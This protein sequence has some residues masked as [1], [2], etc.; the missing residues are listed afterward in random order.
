P[1]DGRCD[2]ELRGELQRV[3]RTQDLLEVPARAR[4]VGDD[5]LHLLVRADDEHRANGQGVVR[6]RVNHVVQRRD[7]PIGVSAQRGV[8][9]GAL[10]LRDGSGP[11]A[12]ILDGVHAQTEH[13]A[14]A[15]VEL[16]L[17]PR[18]LAELGGADRSESLRVREEHAP[19]V[20]EVLVEPNRAFRAI[21][22]EVGS[23]VAESNAHGAFLSWQ[24]TLVLPE[25]TSAVPRSLPTSRAKGAPPAAE[26][27][28]E[29]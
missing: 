28:G 12:M 17:Q 10:R 11:A 9:A 13:L 1:V 25:W 18:D 19:A 24:M 15:L 4:G 2:G 14:V 23:D 5:E 26:E 8:E 22:G 6:V 16:R 21:R 3:D 20:A 29:A 27:A 7:L